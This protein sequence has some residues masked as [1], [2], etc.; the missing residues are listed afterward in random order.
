MAC[1]TPISFGWNDDPSSLE[2]DPRKWQGNDGTGDDHRISD[3]RMGM[4][5]GKHQ[6]SAPAPLQ[7]PRVALPLPLPALDRERW[8]NQYVLGFL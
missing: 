5:S 6:A 8:G 4:N 2:F 3:H 1:I 7:A